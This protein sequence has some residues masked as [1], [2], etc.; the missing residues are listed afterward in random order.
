MNRQPLPKLPVFGWHSLQG[1]PSP[2]PSLLDLPRLNYTTSGRAS[3]LLALQA[4]GVGPGQAVLLPTYHCPS[5][6]APVTHLGATPVFYPID[7]QGTPLL[8]SLQ[9]QDHLRRA[10][11][12]KMQV[13]QGQTCR[14]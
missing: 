1:G 7:E 3:I 13:S 11:S 6:V 4:L 8:Q 5:M 9:Q 12:A 10:R 14:L 2:L